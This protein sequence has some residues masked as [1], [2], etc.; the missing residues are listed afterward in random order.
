VQPRTEYLELLNF[1]AVTVRECEAE[2][3]LR[4]ELCETS[5]IEDC[6]G[7][8]SVTAIKN[9]HVEIRNSPQLIG[10]SLLSGRDL[11]LHNLPNL[12]VLG[13]G[14]IR[15]LDLDVMPRL[16]KLSISG[17]WFPLRN[18]TGMGSE[19][20]RSVRTVIVENLDVPLAKFLLELPEL[21]NLS[22]VCGPL[23]PGA[24]SMLADC[25]NLNFMYVFVNPGLDLLY[26]E[27]AEL[28]Q[29]DTISLY[30]PGSF[31]LPDIGPGAFELPP[32]LRALEISKKL[33]S[34]VL[35]SQIRG[36]YPNAV[37]DAAKDR[38]ILD[39]A[40]P[41]LEFTDQDY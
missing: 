5:V 3:E 33:F 22:I 32:N 23:E 9:V 7:L 31:N 37:W 26:K 18:M 38:F 14:E 13:L 6:P 29:L 41:P 12:E 2:T 28:K 17:Q 4:L 24:V 25:K 35:E 1:T 10:V 16:R 21:Q 30:V 36:L 40:K 34:P 20:F 15:N 27:V 19:T 11:S 8:E 39:P